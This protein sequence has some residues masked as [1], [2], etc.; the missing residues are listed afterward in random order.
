MTTPPD[1][2]GRH[3]G[4]ALIS[5]IFLLVTLA[6]LGAFI[7]VVTTAAQIG[8][9]LDLA[10]VRSYFAARA[11]A[12]WGAAKTLDPTFCAA[13]PSRNIGMLDGVAI[14]VLCTTVAAGDSVEQGLGRIYS[15][16]ATACT[17]PQP[18]TSCPGTVT[19]PN[20]AERRMTILLER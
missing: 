20:Y 16:T 1:R 17:H 12:E 6:A 5:A 4:F 3:G 8:S 11:G 10:V 9:A 18:D 7:A 15:V 14:T 19:A 13:N 2:I